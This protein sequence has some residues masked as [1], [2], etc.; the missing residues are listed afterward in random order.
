MDKINHIGLLSARLNCFTILKIFRSI[1]NLK[2]FSKFNKKNETFFA[3]I[4]DK[5]K[6]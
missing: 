3:L 6:E 1:N 2:K 4:S 5:I